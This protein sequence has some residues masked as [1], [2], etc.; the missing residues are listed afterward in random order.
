M[1]ISILFPSLVLLLISLSTHAEFLIREK[2][3]KRNTAIKINKD[4]PTCY[5][6]NSLFKNV[7]SLRRIVAASKYIFTGKISS[8]HN[9]RRA[10]KYTRNVFKVFVRRVL[11]GDKEELSELL[12]FETRTSNASSRAFIIAEGVRWKKCA[13]SQGW[14]ALLFGGDSFVSQLKL[15]TDPVP[16]SLERVRQD[17]GSIK[18][19]KALGRFI[20]M[21]TTPAG[22]KN[23]R[24]SR[25]PPEQGSDAGCVDRASVSD[26]AGPPATRRTARDK[27]I[28][29]LSIKAIV[30]VNRRT[31]H[32]TITRSMNL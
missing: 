14:A 29:T 4:P 8:V 13:G 22:D 27:F 19:D 3:R 23:K 26:S 21:K 12:N 24:P 20:V 17:T 28:D 5:Y 31:A 15:I 9:K 1:K 18:G 16:S 7:D 10:G 32:N 25:R 2:V 11:K 30:A 6:N